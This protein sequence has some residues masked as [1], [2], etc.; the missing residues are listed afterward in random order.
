MKN[1]EQK[2]KRDSKVDGMNESML[3]EKVKA[4]IEDAV[5]GIVEECVLKKHRV[6]MNKKM[7]CIGSNIRLIG[8]EIIGEEAILEVLRDRLKG[9][10]Y[11]ELRIEKGFFNIYPSK[12]VMPELKMEQSKKDKPK[13]KKV[14]GEEEKKEEIEYPK[15]HFKN[16]LLEF[17]THDLPYGMLPVHNYTIELHKAMFTEE[18]FQLY[19]KYEKA[20]HG[21]DREATNLQRFLCNSPIFDPDVDLNIAESPSLLEATQIDA[22]FRVFKDEGIYPGFGTF[23]LYHRIDGKLVAVNVIDILKEVYVSAYCLYDPDMSFLCLGV[24]TAIR[25]FEYMRL[26]KEKYNPAL[27]YYQLGEMVITCPKVNYKLNYKPGLI[28]CPRTKK[29]IPLDKCLDTINLIAMMPIEEK[30]LL[31]YV[32]LDDIPENIVLRNERLPHLLGPVL[33]KFPFVYEERT[34]LSLGSLN[35]QGKKIIIPSLLEMMI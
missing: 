11:S 10:E 1:E 7:G 14:K 20:V 22:T 30:Q 23:H 31:P 16:Y 32:Q 4:K 9:D 25:E 3:I 6:Q 15:N 12:W 18:L 33:E 34:W 26:I 19:L 27:K 21:K 13:E 28:I 24:V 17:N 29:M 8:G 2:K 35:E 5:R